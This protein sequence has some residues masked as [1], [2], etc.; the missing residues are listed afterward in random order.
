MGFG[1]GLYVV[2]KE[3]KNHEPHNNNLILQPYQSGVT[4]IYSF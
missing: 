2:N 1:A 3:E 4:L